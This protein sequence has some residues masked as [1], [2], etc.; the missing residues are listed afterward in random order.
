MYIITMNLYY[1]GTPEFA[2]PALKILSVDPFFN[3]LGVVTQPDKPGNRNKITPPPVKIAAEQM[4][5]TIFQPKKL[6]KEFLAKIEENKPD[7]IIVAAY[8]EIIPKKLL[9]IPKYGCINIHP[10]LLPKYRG[11]SPLQEALLNGDEE[12]GIAFIKLDEELD[13]GPV[14]LIKRVPI[15]KNDKLTT[16]SNKL[17]ELSAGLLPF[18]LKDIKEEAITPIPQEDSKATFCRKIDKKDGEI[19]LK[20]PVDEILNQIRALNPWP[21]TFLTLKDKNIKILE[22]TTLPANEEINKKTIAFKTSTDLLIPTK[23]QVPGKNPMTA[24][25]FLNGYRDLL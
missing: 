10:S 21:G 23:L 25:E 13:H 1:F 9:E 6:D 17:A 15:E 5:L 18:V 11:A 8:G 12:T 24:S 4:D 2:V 20:R 19:D 14:Y 22:A 3:I 16:L 7:I